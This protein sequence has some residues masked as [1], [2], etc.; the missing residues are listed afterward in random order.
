MKIISVTEVG[1]HEPANLCKVGET[2]R[3]VNH[4]T[5]TH[6]ITGPFDTFTL[7][8]SAQ[9]D[10]VLLKAGTFDIKSDKFQQKGFLNTQ[11]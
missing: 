3:F 7:T 10:V 9:K 8:P 5:I 11:A 6:T 1:F 2:V 4:S